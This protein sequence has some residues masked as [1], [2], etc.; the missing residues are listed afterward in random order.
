MQWAEEFHGWARLMIE[1]HLP[2]DIL[3]AERI[4][5]PEALAKYDLI[6]LPNT[7]YLSDRC[8]EA[9]RGYVRQGGRVLA[10]AETSRYTET[11]APRDDFALADVLGIAHRGSVDGPFAISGHSEP[12]PAMGCVQQVAVVGQT[13]AFMVS[14]DPAGSVSGDADPMPLEPTAWPVFVRRRFGA[15]QSLYAAFAIGRYYT[16]YGY[17]HIG[18]RMREL[19]DALLP[20]RQVATNAPRT[21]EVTVWRQPALPAR[22]SIWPTAVHRGRCRRR[23]ARTRRF[24]PH[25]QCGSSDDRAVCQ[26]AGFRARRRGQRPAGR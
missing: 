6:V 21:V 9:L 20:T 3:V 4:A 18:V 14:V 24:S 1:E 15:G 26:G 17:Q 16:L 23:R 12:E 19:L 22:S 25:S 8:C 2:F 5:A 10:T 13:L 7:A 11:G